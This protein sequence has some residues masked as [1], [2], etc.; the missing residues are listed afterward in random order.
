MAQKVTA[1]VKLQIPAGQATPGQPIGP[2][3]GQHGV[4]IM[5][6]V[7]EYNARTANQVGEIVPV[8]IT[9]FQD[10]SFNFV[11]KTPPAPAL[12]KKAAGVPKAAANPLTERVG[13]VTRAQVREIAQRKMP[14]LNAYDIDEAM[15]MIEG[16]ARSMGIAVVED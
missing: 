3:L 13:T 12:L 5:Q 1:I 10:R 4:N 7:K 9:I 6:F 16:T 14:D 15:R 2:A 8:E 11:T